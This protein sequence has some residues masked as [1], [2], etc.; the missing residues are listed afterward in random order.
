MNTE[1]SQPLVEMSVSLGELA[2]KVTATA[3][4]NKIKTIKDEKNV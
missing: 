1:H 3:V 2:I 4:T